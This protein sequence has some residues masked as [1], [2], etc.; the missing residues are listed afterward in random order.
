MRRTALCC[1]L[2]TMLGGASL[3]AAAPPQKPAA[4]K[5][6][7]FEAHVKLAGLFFDNFFQA[8]EGSPEEDVLGASVEGGL[9]VQVREESP[10]KAYLEADYIIY[11]DFDPSTGITAGLRREGKPHAWD[12]SAQYLKGRPSREVRDE[13][14]RADVLGVSGQYSYRVTEDFEVIGLGEY[15]HETFELSEDK[16]NDVYNLG[17]ALRY[18]GFGW[19]FSPE[20]GFRLGG[21]DVVVGDEDFSQREAFV[22]LR[23]SPTSAL[24]LT[25]RYRRRSRDY[26]VEDPRAANFGRE[27]TR[28]QLTATADWRHGASL[29]WNLY[30]ALEDSDSTR[31]VGVFRTQMLSL[32]FTIG[33]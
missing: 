25:L 11:Q 10:L 24:Y 13:F 20:I 8:P 4:K 26:S 27:D 18:R 28:K 32:G 29:T 22:R 9:A 16:A 19:R 1:S 30:Y 7:R 23:W 17:A 5:P 15:R 12:V 6:D 33:F 3:L 31:P 2:A 21:R 14:D